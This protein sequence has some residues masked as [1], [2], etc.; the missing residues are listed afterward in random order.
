MSNLKATSPNAQNSTYSWKTNLLAQV[1][2]KY[3][4][5]TVYNFTADTISLVF[6][7]HLKEMTIG[8]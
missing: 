6:A 4:N 2:I 3:V 7:N 8:T 1:F 5:I